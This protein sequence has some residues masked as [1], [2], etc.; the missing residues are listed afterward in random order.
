MGHASRASNQQGEGRLG[1]E[2]IARLKQFRQQRLQSMRAQRT[3]NLV[4][5]RLLGRQTQ[6]LTWRVLGAGPVHGSGP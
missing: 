2:R 3:R 6:A 5:A 4:R 1:S